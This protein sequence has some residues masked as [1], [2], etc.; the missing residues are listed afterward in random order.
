MNVDL[1][2]RLCEIPGVPGREERVREFIEKEIDGLFDEIEV[3]PMGSLIC[4]RKATRKGRGRAAKPVVLIAAHMDEIGF[5]VRHVDDDGFLWLNAAGGFDPRNLFSRRVLVCTDSGDHVGVMNPGGKPIHIS[6]PEER[7][8]VPAVEDF[9]IDLGMP[10]DKVKKTVKI[11]D[12]VVMHEPFLEQPESVVSKA[13]DNRFACWTAIE[14]VRKLDRARG[15]AGK[16]GCDIVVAF[17]VQEEVGL[18]GAVVAANR[19]GADYGIGLDVTL[20]CDTPGVPTTQRVTRQ[21]DGAAVMVQDS[22]MISDYQLV[23]EFCAVARKHRIPHQRCIL[24]RGG[25]DG[26]A[27]Q[28]SGGGARC[29]ALTSGTRYIHTVTESMRKSDAEAA[30]DL[31]AAWLAQAK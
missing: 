24:G 14:A 31:L 10:A 26:A 28:R 30:V 6:S 7:S 2:K 1:L 3:D 9:F 17:T 27:I 23:D 16:H 25:Q 29:V 13:L 4:T 19:G 22:S 20:S 18:R 8:R 11:G 15:A 21:G 5:Y 12:Y